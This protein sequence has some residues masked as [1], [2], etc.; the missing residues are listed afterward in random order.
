[1]REKSTDV[2]II[3][4]KKNLKRPS[5]SESLVYVRNIAYLNQTQIKGCAEI[6][7]YCANTIWR[8]NK[9]YINANSKNASTRFGDMTRN[10]C[11][12]VK[13]DHSKT[14]FFVTC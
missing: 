7:F 12:I 1:M 11:F 10:D 2:I 3:K 4:S 6:W 13:T 14:N 9:D 5:Y 8:D